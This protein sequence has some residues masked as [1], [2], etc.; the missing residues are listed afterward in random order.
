LRIPH[1]AVEKRRHPRYCQALGAVVN[2]VR[3]VA[4][5]VNVRD[6]EQGAKSRER[7]RMSFSEDPTQGETAG[8]PPGEDPMSP[9]SAGARGSE[10]PT[11]GGTIG[12][13]EGED[14]TQ[15]TGVGE[16]EYEDPSQGS[17]IGNPPGEDPTAV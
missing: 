4:A 8:N 1:L 7:S 2:P 13:P 14:P 10:D 11:Q 9:G 16:D 17:N 6:A 15:G 5:H 12:D 3:R